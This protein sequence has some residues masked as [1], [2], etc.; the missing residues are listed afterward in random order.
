MTGVVKRVFRNG[1]GFIRAEDRTD[2]FFHVD[3]VEDFLTLAQ[4]DRVVFEPMVPQPERGP[5]AL[6]VALLA[7]GNEDTHG[8]GGQR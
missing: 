4:D 6:R 1:Y 8:S 5:R 3:D 2:F 7:G